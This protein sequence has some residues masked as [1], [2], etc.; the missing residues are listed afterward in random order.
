MFRKTISNSQKPSSNLIVIHNSPVNISEE[1]PE[2]RKKK[3]IRFLSIDPGTKNFALRI[4]TRYFDGRI[5]GEIMMKP[6]FTND[7]NLSVCPLYNLVIA[8]LEQFSDWFSTI[9]VVIIERQLPINYKMVRMSQHL[10][11]YCLIRIPSA[12]ILE[13]DSTIKT[14]ELEAPPRLDKREVKK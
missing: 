4:E 13:I 5:I 9:D 8:F 12:H 11:S 7:D 10:I 1:I 3:Y 14:K 6:D 2:N